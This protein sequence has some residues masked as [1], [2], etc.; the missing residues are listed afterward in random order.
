MSYLVIDFGTS[1]CR[2]SIVSPKGLIISQS[3]EPVEIMVAGSSA[4]IDTDLVWTT[5][6]RVIRAE[7]AKH[8]DEQIDAVGVSAMLGYVFLD[9]ENTP[10]RPAFIWMDNRARAEADE[11]LQV[12]T[13]DELYRKTGRKM[14]PELLAPKILWLRK[15]EPELS[16]K[17]RK[18]IGLK[19]E[20]IRRL[21][22]SVQTDYAHLNY[23]LLYN[24]HRGVLDEEIISAL[25]ISADLFPPAHVSTDI[26]G[27]VSKE[28]GQQ[29][30]LKAGIPVVSGSSDG[31]TAMY[32]GGI[33]EKDRAV[34]VSGTTDVLMTLAPEEVEDHTGILSLN[35]GMVKGTY[36]IGGVMGLSGGT[37]HRIGNLF[38]WKLDELI[39][40]V[41][42]V[43]PGAG[44]LIFVPGLSGERA[45]YWKENITGS[46]IGLT[47][48][49]QPEHVLR[50]L[51]EG[52]SFRIR[53]LM[54]ILKKNG[55]VP[56]VINIVGGCSGIDIWNQIRADVTGLEVVRLSETEATSLGTAL[57]CRTGIGESSNLK[58]ATTDWIRADRV[59]QPVP[60][61]HAEYLKFAEIFEKYIRIS[62]EI[63]DGLREYRHESKKP[64]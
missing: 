56:R 43:R 20:I 58:Q 42:R 26:V 21:T 62:E 39:E 17:M 35:T 13:E 49:H 63:Y 23:S 59:Y 40:K 5:V 57:F 48:A 3:R 25:K 47:L 52:T 32:G 7:A 36:A 2:A 27:A 61:N 14:S 41:R 54:Q 51:F 18:I 29:L 19:D 28:C 15:H 46:L 60:E 44:G 50:A 34:L 30:G 10:L 31:T 37:L 9:S 16:G 64:V 12:F 33:L 38:Q 24:V 45:P 22:G 4:E 6:Q 8:P 1:S 55:L 11:I 53:K